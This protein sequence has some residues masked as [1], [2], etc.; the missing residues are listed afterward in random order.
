M[1]RL[2]RTTSSLV[3]C[4]MLL[5]FCLIA[6]GDGAVSVRADTPASEEAAR[7]RIAE[8]HEDSTAKKVVMVPV[9]VI[10][11]PFWLIGKG[12]EA[13]LLTVENRHLIEKS[14]AFSEKLTRRGLT[15]L[16]GVGYDGAGFGGG[17]EWTPPVTPITPTVSGAIS[18]NLYQVYR[19]RLDF[20]GLVGN[21]V[22]L[23]GETRYRVLPQEDFYGIGPGS[24]RE[25]RTTYKLEQTLVPL[26]VNRPFTPK[27]QFD[28]S[29][30]YNNSNTYSGEDERW[31]STEEVFSP[32]EVPGLDTGAEMVTA[33]V[34]LSYLGF[35]RPGDPRSGIFA[36]A[37]VGVSAEIDGLP[38]DYYRAYA[39]FFGFL[40]VLGGGNRFGPRGSIGVRVYADINEPI[41][42]DGVVPFFK[43][44]RVGGSNTLRGFREF[45][46]TDNNAAVFNVEYK[47]PIQHLLEAVLFW[48]EGQVW[49]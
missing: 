37:L 13:G 42:E 12:I 5:F 31:P 3:V 17:V 48:D 28:A 1:I 49:G 32:D 27:I 10:A 41:K 45:R 6:F 24:K 4:G 44:P 33:T 15:I 22:G 20:S 43:M 46:F 47:Y 21:K 23:A 38:Y 30:E 16:Y 2:A 7:E 19:V 36:K 26:T 34:A 35:D 8:K 39:E 25:D 14:A 11:F 9:K 18:Y 29:V 40:P